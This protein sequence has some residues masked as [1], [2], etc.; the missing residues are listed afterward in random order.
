MIDYEVGEIP[1]VGLGVEVRDD[2]D[3]LINT[4]GY[5]SVNLELRGTDDEDVDLTGVTITAVPTALGTYVVEW[6]R[7]RSIFTKRGKYL[8]RFELRKL[9]GTREYTRPTEIRVR[10]FGRLNN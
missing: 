10:E 9:D 1:S 8:M 3:N 7:D 5:S 4:V 6:P 2:R